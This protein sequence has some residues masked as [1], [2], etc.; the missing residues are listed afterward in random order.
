MTLSYHTLCYNS[1][2]TIAPPCQGSLLLSLPCH[3]LPGHLL[4]GL[5]PASA[6]TW[7]CAIVWCTDDCHTRKGSNTHC[8]GS[9]QWVRSVEWVGSAAEG[10]GG[11]SPSYSC[12][13]SIGIEPQLSH[14][15]IHS[16]PCKVISGAAAEIAQRQPALQVTSQEVPTPV[17]LSGGG[18]LRHQSLQG[19]LN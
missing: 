16:L 18:W 5:L 14:Q 2:T 11:G 15:H 8:R 6:L 13:C 4:D 7:T 17:P 9:E 19:L 3:P 10:T 12:L 1:P